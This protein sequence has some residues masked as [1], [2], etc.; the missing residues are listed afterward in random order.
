MSKRFNLN[1]LLVGQ[2]DKLH[3]LLALSREERRRLRNLVHY[4]KNIN[5]S[6]PMKTLLAEMSL[7]FKNSEAQNFVADYLQARNVLWDCQHD[8]TFYK[9]ANVGLHT[10]DF[11]EYFTLII[12]VRGRG[13]VEVIDK[14]K[15]KDMKSDA[16]RASCIFNHQVISYDLADG[17]FIFDQ[18]K[19]HCFFSQTAA[20]EMLI[21]YVKRTEIKKLAAP[22]VT[23]NHE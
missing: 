5:K 17:P 15:S 1:D 4:G 14:S 9:I 11:H 20:C 18:T 21:T 13:L 12:P 19:P 7:D 2:R 8:T 6:L 16:W 22:K 3:H 23:N 10:D